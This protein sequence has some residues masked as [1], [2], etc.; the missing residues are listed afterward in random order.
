MQDYWQQRIHKGKLPSAERRLVLTL[1]A[2]QRGLCT[3]CGLDLIEGAEYQ[4]DDVHDWVN[5]F[6]ASSRALNVH[7]VV[8]RGAGDSNELKNLELRHTACHQHSNTTLVTTGESSAS[9]RGQL[10]PCVS[11]DALTPRSRRPRSSTEPRVVVQMRASRVTSRAASS[12]EL[13]GR[14]AIRASHTSSRGALGSRTALLSTAIPWSRS[15]A[16][17]RSSIMPSV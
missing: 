5:W 12:T 14:A 6:S 17:L 11:R 9:P 7:H 8:Y 16:A 10:E 1:A 15:S 13:A 4:R 2:R 3:G